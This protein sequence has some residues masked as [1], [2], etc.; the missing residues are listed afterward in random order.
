MRTATYANNEV[1]DLY[2]R[3]QKRKKELR[4]RRVEYDDSPIIISRGRF[5]YVALGMLG[6]LIACMF[7]M[8]CMNSVYSYRLDYLQEEVQRLEDLNKELNDKIA[9]VEEERNT[10][11][12]LLQEVSGIAVDLDVQV[13]ELAD[14]I[15]EQNELIA[16]YEE[17]EE[18]FDKYEYA[19]IRTDGTRTDIKYSELN[20]L[21]SL[22]EEKELGDS[23]IDLVLSLSMTESQ[24]TEKA[25]NPE[26]T[27]RG[28][29]QILAGTGKMVYEKFMGNGSGSY[30]H[31]YAFNGEINLQMMVYYLE[32]LG[33]KYSNNM[34]L[35]MNEYRGD[36]DQAYNQKVNRYLSKAGTDIMSIVIRP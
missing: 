19:I 21:I 26:S 25:A 4:R 3:T 27:A 12:G 6:F 31:D 18:L 34:T 30:N 20:T 11:L 24:G 23:V 17:R 35:V 1:R 32:W 36:L 29:G 2:K 10:A 8:L 9:S 15:N 7:M 5:F 33:K 13:T 16:S 28:Y 22:V 14:Q